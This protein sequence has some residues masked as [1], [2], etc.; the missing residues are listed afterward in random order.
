MVF[1]L[2]DIIKIGMKGPINKSEVK[3]KMIIG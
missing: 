1:T 3:R 2:S